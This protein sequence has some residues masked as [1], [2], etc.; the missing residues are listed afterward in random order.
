[1][2]ASSSCFAHRHRCR[3]RRREDGLVVANAEPSG[4]LSVTVPSSVGRRH[5]RPAVATYTPR[6]P[7]IEPELHFCDDWADLSTTRIELPGRIGLLADS[8]LNR[9][10]AGAHLESGLRKPRV[11]ARH[12]R[13]DPPK[14]LIKE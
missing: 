10:S 6:Y 2:P 7:L 8:D 12:G 14:D 13:T 4:P 3:V 1:M 5:V 9:H 11:P